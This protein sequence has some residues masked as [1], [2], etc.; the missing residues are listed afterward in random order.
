[1]IELEAFHIPEALHFRHELHVCWVAIADH[2][3]QAK[4]TQSYFQRSRWSTL[5]HKDRSATLNVVVAKDVDPRA[6][7]NRLLNT[8]ICERRDV[9]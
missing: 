3:E 8:V 1:M 5:L 7:P 2:I 9:G 6:N 4:G